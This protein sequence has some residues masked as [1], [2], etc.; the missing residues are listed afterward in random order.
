M[1]WAGVKVVFHV[2]VCYIPNDGRE[3]TRDPSQ[4]EPSGQYLIRSLE[5]LQKT[6]VTVVTWSPPWSLG[7]LFY[8][9]VSPS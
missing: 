9:R 7:V 2:F 5:V 4:G 6:V 1:S 3:I 8:R